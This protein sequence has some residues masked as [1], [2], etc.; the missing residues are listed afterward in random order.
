LGKTIIRE[1]EVNDERGFA[2]FL[3]KLN[4]VNLG[5]VT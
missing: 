5:A 3:L 4:A 2:E 1:L